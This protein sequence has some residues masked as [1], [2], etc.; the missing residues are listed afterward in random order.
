AHLVDHEPGRVVAGVRLDVVR[1]RFREHLGGGDG[2]VVDERP[3]VVAVRAADLGDGNTP[4]IDFGLVDFD[5]VLFFRQHLTEAVKAEAPRPGSA[6]R[7]LVV[8]AE[9]RLLYAASP[10]RAAAAPLEAVATQE[11]R[12]PLPDV[13]EARHVDP[14]G[15]IADGVTVGRAIDPAVGTATHDVIHQILADL[16]ARVREAGSGIEQDAR[17]LDR[18]RAQEDDARLELDRVLGLPVDHAYAGRAPAPLV[19][20]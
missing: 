11:R 7:L 13:A 15:P 3:L 9:A 17:R 19:V 5:D 10:V 1:P 16:A 2:H 12:L 8:G 14:V 18:G 20:R 6:Q 4:R